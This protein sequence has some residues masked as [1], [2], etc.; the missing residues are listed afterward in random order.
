[1]VTRSGT[2]DLHGSAFEFLRNSALDANGFE[3]NRL[4]PAGDRPCSL[5]PSDPQCK[6]Q[7]FPL[8]PIRLHVERPCR[9]AFVRFQS[10]ARQTV[11]SL[12]P[13]M[14][15]PTPDGVHGDHGSLVGDA[16]G[17]LQ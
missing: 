11:L 2:R 4:N 14:G 3:R 8:Q 7:P 13:G 1:M 12:G 15:P 9:F 17:R 16:A 6:P 5:F 10:R